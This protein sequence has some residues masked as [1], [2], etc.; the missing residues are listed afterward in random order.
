MEMDNK[1]ADAR[2]VLDWEAQWACAMGRRPPKPFVQMGTGTGGY[3][4]H[5][6]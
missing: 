3:L 1:M 2:R 4:F 6:R 5:V